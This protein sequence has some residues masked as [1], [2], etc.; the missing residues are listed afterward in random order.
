MPTGMVLPAATP[1]PP[2]NHPKIMGLAVKNVWE[3]WAKD[4]KKVYVGYYWYE[5]VGRY[6]KVMVATKKGLG[7]M[8]KV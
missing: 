7:G 6:E 2:Q 1:L 5:K 3:A 4:K 8:K